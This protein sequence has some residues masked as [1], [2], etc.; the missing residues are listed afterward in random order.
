MKS[1]KSIMKVKNHTL[2]NLRFRK[3]SIVYTNCNEEAIVVASNNSFQLTF[4]EEILRCNVFK[5]IAACLSS[6][7]LF[8]FFLFL[9]LSFFLSFFFSL[10]RL[11][12]FMSR[13]KFHDSWLYVLPFHTT[14][15]LTHF[16]LLNEDCWS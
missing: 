1:S 5:P 16:P 4:H 12:L 10:S 3:S 8:S 6:F 7:F 2:E 13:K 9:F 14:L 11:N 15:L